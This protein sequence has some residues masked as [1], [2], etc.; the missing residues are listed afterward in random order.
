MKH[1]HLRTL[2]ACGCV[3]LTACQPSGPAEDFEDG[4][5]QFHITALWTEPEGGVASPTDPL[6]DAD[7]TPADDAASWSL[8]VS[9]NRD[10]LVLT[11]V[12]ADEAT[13]DGTLGDPVGDRLHYDLAE[14]VFA[15]GRF[16]VWTDGALK[17]ELTIYGSGV[18]IVQSARGD[19]VRIIGL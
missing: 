2:C 10:T 19:L 17:A 8:F 9:D 5:W 13:I 1:R 18:P 6:D 16:E 11:E 12:S 4:S 7:F 3:A 15:G 14:G